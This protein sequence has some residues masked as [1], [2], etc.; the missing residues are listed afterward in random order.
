[1]TAEEFSN[2]YELETRKGILIHDNVYKFAIEFA[3]YHVNLAKTEILEKAKITYCS[4]WSMDQCID[5]KSILD[6][7]PLENIK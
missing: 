3:K 6:A 4:E 7:Y 2:K 1:M 5:R